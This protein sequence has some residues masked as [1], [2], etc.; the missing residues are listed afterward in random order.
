MKEA[1]MDI[2]EITYSREMYEAKPRPFVSAFIYIFLIIIIVTIGF[3]AIGN[4]DIVT[5]A[6]GVVRPNQ[7]VSTVKSSIVGEVTEV[8]Y[9]NGQLVN[10]GDVLLALDYSAQN[11]S[12][13]LI[14]T[15][16]SEKRNALQM[17]EKYK[18]SINQD[19]N[20]FNKDVEESYYNKFEKYRLNKRI[21]NNDIK[22]N[23]NLS[24]VQQTSVREQLSVLKKENDYIDLLE[25]SIR[26]NENKILGSGLV[27]QYYSSK[28]EKYQLDYITLQKQYE[29]QVFEIKLGQN[30]KLSDKTLEEVKLD[31]FGYGLIKEAIDHGSNKFVYLSNKD[32]TEYE[33]TNYKREFNAY[34]TTSNQLE[35]TYNN[36]KKNYEL[37][38]SLQDIAV[39]I[40]QVELAK[41]NMDQSFNE[42]VNYESNYYVE[43]TNRL[44]ELEL[45]LLEL[46]VSNNMEHSK[47]TILEN[48]QLSM[49]RALN[50]FRTDTLVVLKEQKNT[51]RQSINQLEQS[52]KQL[53]VESE[54]EL[55]DESGEYA[56][57]EYFKTNELIQTIQEIEALEDEMIQLETNLAQVNKE[58][59]NSI[60]KAP[61]SGRINII[62]DVVTGD[63]LF[64]GT[65][66]FT[67]VPEDDTT[68]KVQIL[69]SNKD[70]AKVAI[71]DS[72]KYHFQALPYR[73]YGELTG[74]ITKIGSDTQFDDARGQSY[75]TVEAT[76]N[77]RVAY[78]YK[79]NMSDVKVG[80]ISEAQVI[81]DQKTILRFLLEKID[82]L[83]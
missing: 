31:Y 71:G 35:T 30:S 55:L 77:E 43:L 65:E 14:Q 5:K 72:I 66:I 56:S 75:Y 45:R 9:E 6:N 57:I 8:N 12:K 38:L 81:T 10:K 52:L 49:E 22:Y 50:K 83:D 18:K 46:E 60:I 11:I 25:Q 59:E 4:I 42:W 3:T 23:I 7:Q 40:N 34:I 27:A 37:N 64:T 29:D 19:E 70:V 76:L 53:Q 28:Y 24:K 1:I 21:N 79:G 33:V 82:I 47:E 69:L 2:S 13:E 62:T 67:I 68:Y 54:K 74:H 51:N 73:E 26:S 61:Q 20:L 16:L 36:A 63:T 48:I 44:L 41:Q 17:L 80:M 15:K 58:I 39:T 32:Y 78:D